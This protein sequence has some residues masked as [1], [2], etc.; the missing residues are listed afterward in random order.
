MI[1]AFR[2]ARFGVAMAAVS[3]SL[4]IAA[5]IAAANEANGNAS[6]MGIELSAISPP[7]TSGEIAGGAPAFV[8]EVRELAA[9]FGLPQGGVDRLIARAHAGSHDACDSEG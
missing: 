2:R 4:T 3:V 5:P 6:C 1:A 7:G 8:L 9:S